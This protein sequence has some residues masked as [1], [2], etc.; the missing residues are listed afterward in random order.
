MSWHN[1]HRD[2]AGQMYIPIN[3]AAYSPNTVNG[4]YPKQATQ[5]QGRGF[6]TAPKR[7]ATGP[8]VRAASD[9]FADVWSQPRLFFN[10][11]EQAE[12]QFLVN[13]MRFEISNLQS[14]VV[15]QNVLIQLNRVSHELAVRVASAIGM[16]APQADFKYYHNNKTVNVG[17]FGKPL[18]KIDGLKVGYLTTA[19][20]TNATSSLKS[21]LSASQVDLVVV[22]E[23]LGVGI[24]QTYSATD[25]IQFDA[26]ILSD[27]S[28]SLF[29][30]N[31]SSTFFPLGRPTQIVSD[32]YRFGKPIAAIGR[33]SVALKA[34]SI[35][36]GNG[37][38]T[39][40]GLSQAADQLKEGLKTFKFLNRFPIDR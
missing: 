31:T 9:T 40:S 12:Q 1:N 38:Y 15:K 22:A 2:G 10:S 35:P 16:T 8:V 24:D 39:S 7:A 6:F 29:S 19:D 26:I 3:P 37:V 14:S 28:A 20:S 32:S 4:G 18:A 13:A 33:G 27:E 23:R 21:I 34:A 36:N 5:S 25:A 30:T 17:V 11:L